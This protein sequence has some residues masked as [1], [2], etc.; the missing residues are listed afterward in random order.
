MP[1]GYCSIS[2]SSTEVLDMGVPLPYMDELLS[3]NGQNLT[4]Q[5][6]TIMGEDGNAAQPSREICGELLPSLSA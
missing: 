2:S 5:V 1:A 3:Q 6:H 4:F